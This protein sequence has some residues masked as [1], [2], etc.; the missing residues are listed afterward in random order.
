MAKFEAGNTVSLK[1]GAAAGAKAIE[2]GT[3]LTGLAAVV[4]SEVKADLETLGAAGIIQNQATRLETVSRL[5]F[6]A[7]VA[8]IQSGDLAKADSYCARY[9]WLANSSIR[10][11]AEV[12]RS[13]KNTPKHGAAKVLDAINLDEGGN[14]DD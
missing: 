13:A 11:W 8:S 7:F 3:P 10:A 1:H 9:G 2:K 4:E 5:Y 14:N 6:D 12:V